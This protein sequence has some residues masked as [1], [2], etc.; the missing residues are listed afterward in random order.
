MPKALLW[1][2]ANLINK[3]VYSSLANAE[4][5]RDPAWSEAHTST[6]SE[7][8]AMKN[9]DTTRP[10]TMSSVRKIVWSVLSDQILVHFL[11][12]PS[13]ALNTSTTLPLKYSLSTTTPSFVHTL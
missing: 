5:I 3:V 12:F 8:V 11:I 2:G 7:S 10:S 13:S 4:F 9:A 1:L 6:A